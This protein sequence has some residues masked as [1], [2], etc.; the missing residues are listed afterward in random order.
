MA[1][2]RSRYGR[3]LKKGE[4]P[5]GKRV[6]VIGAGIAGIQASLDL[7]DAG[8][9][10]TL[11]EKQPSIGGNM[12]RLSRTF[13]TGDCSTCILSPKMAAANDHPNIELHT[14]SEVTEVQ[15]FLGNFAISIREKP[16]Y[17]NSAACIACGLCEEKCPVKI[18]D[19]FNGNLS[20]TKAVHLQFDYAVPFK[21]FIE[22]EHCLR[23]KKGGKVCGIC[24][25]VCP[26]QAI[27]FSM[28][29]KI[30]E[31]TVDTIIVAT[32][33]DIYDAREKPEY[34]FGKIP[35]VI[36]GMQME[37]IIVKMAEGV[38]LH[39]VGKK[40]AF[41]QCVGSRDKQIGRPYCSRVCCMYAIKQAALLKSADPSRDVYIFY[42]DIRAF[43][44]G[45]EEYYNAAQEAGV[46]FIRGKAAELRQNPETGRVVVKA[47]DT[48]N[49]R[50]IEAEFDTVSLSVGVGPSSG[51]GPVASLLKLARSADGFF[52]EAHPKFRPVDTLV[53][54]V[55]LAGMAQGP[56]DIP[57]TVSQA[58]GAAARAIALMNRGTYYFDPQFAFVEA[59]RCTGCE[60]CLSSCPYDAISMKNGKAEINS[61]LCTGCG[62]CIGHCPDRAIDM[63]LYSTEQLRAEIRRA[64]E[65]RSEGEVRI[66]IFADDMTTYRLVDSVGTAKMSY[67]SNSRLIRI[68]SGG[69]VT[70]E[71]ILEAFAG[72]ADAVL[73]A[74]AEEKSSP[75]ATSKIEML[76]NVAA[77]REVLE[78]AGIEIERLQGMEF[79]TVMLAKFV[80]IVNDLDSYVRR[81]GVID[82]ERRSR[83]L[84]GPSAAV[85]TAGTPSASTG[86]PIGGEHEE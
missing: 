59:D 36:N 4:I 54:G 33:Y 47:E 24:E 62:V 84:D 64:T 1:I 37:R 48:L 11:V 19:E 55:F 39:T 31:K 43:G 41:I 69:R 67:S 81:V 30:V 5:I 18:P 51:S 57:D 9:E 74:D 77:A 63:H 56:K 68:P 72:G 40:V 66:L 27:D 82:R 32:G 80:K 44:K 25:K 58:S 42:I 76:R 38:S 52:Q 14:Y 45:Y 23:L 29:E 50:I 73:I 79:V 83:L 34:G 8:F 86:R 75:Y 13:P 70:T 16:R 26:E 15:G 7:A 22:E 78:R 60:L 17:V 3:A 20:K 49:R 28:T 46:K 2:E 10:V 53:P 21:Y 65:K 61:A 35:G 71:L 6:L 85:V 12:A